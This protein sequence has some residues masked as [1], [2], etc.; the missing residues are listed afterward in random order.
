MRVEQSYPAPVH[1]ISTL[2]PRNRPQGYASRQINFRSDPVNKLTRR[3][4]GRWIRKL[5][6]VTDVD[7]ITRHRYRRAE[8]FYDIIVDNV[9]GNVQGYRN[10]VPVAVTGDLSGY[11]SDNM[12]LATI[13]DT[14][15]IVNSNTTVAMLPD[16]DVDEVGL[17]S[18]INITSALNYSERIK[19]TVTGTNALRY[20][21]T[22]FVPSLGT[23]N[24]DYDRADAARATSAVAK[25][26]AEE[27]LATTPGIF[28]TTYKG[29]TVGVK[30]TDDSG[31]VQLEIES[32]QGDRS[33]VAINRIIE[34]TDGLPLYANVGTRVTVRPDPTSDK[35]TY[36]LQA[37]RV[38]DDPT[39]ELLE[40]VVW[41]EDRSPDEPHSFNTATMPHVIEWNGTGFTVAETAFKS[42]QSGDDESAT[43]PDFI[44]ETIETIGY[45]QKRLVF[46]SG[47]NTIMSETDDELNFWRQS[48]VQLL[49]TDPVSISSS[50]LGTDTL[51]HLVPHN[52]DLLIIS[53]NSQFKLSG[54]EA[55]TP[56]T[57]SMP[58][59][60]KYECQISVPPVTIGNSVYF[61]IDYGDSTGLQ[62]Y[63]GEENTG[64]D[65]A[66][67]VTH[68]II[69]YLPG[70]VEEMTAS[71][72]LEMIAL[73][74]EDSDDNVIFVYE[75]YTNGG[76]RQQ[77]SW[78]EWHLPEG[79]KVID[80]QF[81]RNVLIATVAEGNDLFE[82]H[83]DMYTRV[84]GSPD[85]VFLD[86][87][88]VLPTDGV[89]ATLPD[90]YNET[91]I[92]A[93]RGA[94][95][96][97][98]LN[99]VGFTV[100]GRTMTFEEPIDAGDVYVGRE[101]TSTYRPTRPFKYERDGSTIT[102][103]RLRVG[104][105][106]MSLVE[107]NELK[108]RTVSEHYPDAVEME[109]N[110]RYVGQTIIGTI[111]TFTGDWLASFSQDAAYAEAEFYCDNYLGCTIAGISWEGQYYQ[112]KKRM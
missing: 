66:S 15:Y 78:S 101:F 19:V 63:T 90:D 102:T 2:A 50:E 41:S 5:E 29:S 16:T 57:A 71:P 6:G 44:G 53:S 10:G 98:E 42:R 3:P 79:N 35:G 74:T 103:D 24:P 72:N 4:A 107:T 88:L 99:K 94:G 25:G 43:P 112:S 49:V 59:T 51:L 45:F 82:K 18:H 23:S 97:F 81:S 52:R 32:G 22:Y 110:A 31:P 96:E 8:A 21:A 36:Y 46:V 89:T 85:D 38:A 11:I 20:T 40:E 105:Y 33:S 37:E 1:G 48:A 95:T 70:N 14:T 91:G 47:N 87:M 83:F 58:L 84:T 61:P 9:T 80:L 73:T 62:E 111:T 56:Q 76:E 17:M 60:T 54:S 68:H 30:M 106:I 75:Q 69:G 104:K 27:I 13:E 26:I 109:F 77:Q 108:M 7:Q 39:G 65:F 86:D 92:I 64:Q 12:R 93:V 55:V 28:T 100:V 34:S 67:P